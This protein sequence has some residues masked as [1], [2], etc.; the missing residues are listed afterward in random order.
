MI[1]YVY[2]DILR[3]QAILKYQRDAPMIKPSKQRIIT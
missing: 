2:N 1:Y 3:L